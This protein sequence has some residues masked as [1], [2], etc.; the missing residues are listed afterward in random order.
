MIYTFALLLKL[1]VSLSATWQLQ[2]LVK[3][4]GK[5]CLMAEYSGFVELKNCYM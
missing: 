3:L 2:L 4:L 1:L 5:R